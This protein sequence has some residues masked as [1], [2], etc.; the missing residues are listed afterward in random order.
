M[1]D[2]DKLTYWEKRAAWL[3][4]QQHDEGTQHI[5]TIIK[6]YEQAQRYLVAEANHIYKRYLDKSGLS[7][8]DVAK[9][10]N[11]K[12]KPSDLVLLRQLIKTTD[13]FTVKKQIQ[14][15]MDG[16]SVKSR[17]TRLELLRAKA[18]VVAK[19]LADVQLA[20]SEPYYID[21][22][23]DAYN[24]ASAEAIIGQAQKDF[25]VY[26]GET[27]PE[28]NNA[29]K[30]EFINQS[31]KVVH[32][33]DVNNDKPVTNFK[34]M[35][36]DYVKQMLDEPWQGANYS[37]RIW[38]NTD[39]LAKR[40]QSLFAAKQMNGMSERDMAQAIM[41]EFATNAYQARRLIRTESAYM[42]NQ[43]RLKAWQTHHVEEYSL[44][45]VLD[46][47]TSSICRHMD[48]K[49]FKVKDAR[50]AGKDGNYPPFH[51]NCRTI[52]VAHFTNSTN[53]GNRTAIDPIANQRMRIPADATYRDWEKLLIHKHGIGLIKQAEAEK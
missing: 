39:E 3:E 8:D 12:I 48:G 2:K 4:Q 40:L 22:M 36:T 25:N 17:I 52:A 26:Q 45:A 38:D 34:E 44:L 29:G 47:R 41:K 7:A 33:L 35:S 46:F 24:H 43:A 27:V 51:P 6:A 53:G 5:V 23:Q 1:M 10:L 50:V 18:Y 42:S 37:K 28:I 21:V 30:I 31:G 16:L 20:E 14:I 15:Y 13:D 49:V 11:T 32:S 19:K 9:I